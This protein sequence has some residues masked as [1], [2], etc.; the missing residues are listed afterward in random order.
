MLSSCVMVASG[1]M[2]AVERGLRYAYKSRRLKRRDA[3]KEWIQQMGAG[4]REY[5]LP[6]SRMIFGLQLSEIGVNR[7][8][9]AVLAKEEP[10]SFRA[11]V[12]E[13][14]RNLRKAVAN[15]D[16]RVKGFAAPSDPDA[17]PDA[18]P[19][20]T[21]APDGKKAAPLS[22]AAAE[23]AAAATGVTL[24]SSA[25]DADAAGDAADELSDKLGGLTVSLDAA[26]PQQQQ[27]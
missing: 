3:R 15:E 4:A 13:C 1:G 25:V 11:I 18:A 16:Y 22:A 20:A 21:P 12:D 17:T 24:P 26:P 5:D 8:M 7:K 6:Y 14:K 2:N 27:A 10:Y 19:G 9:L 23:I